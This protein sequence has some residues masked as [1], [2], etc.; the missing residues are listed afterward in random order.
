MKLFCF[1]LLLLP[2]VVTIGQ[3]L[4]FKK[5]NTSSSAS[6]RGLS[7]VDNRTAWVSGTKGSVGRTTDGGKTWNIQRIPGFE[8]LDFRSLYA[9]NSERAIIAN[10][11]SPA[12][13]LI[14]TNGGKSWKTVYT[15]DQKDAFF[16]GIDFWDDQNGLIYGDP[17]EGKMLL[18]RTTDGGL[19][20]NP[21]KEPPMLETGEASF[22]ASGTGIRCTNKKAVMICTGGTVSRLWIS[23]NQG[24]HWTNLP[25]PILQG[26]SSTGIFSF[27]LHN[28][29]L[30]IVGGDYKN[31]A[32]N[33]NHNF[34]SGDGGKQWTSPVTPVRGYRECIEVIAEKTLVS[35]GPTGT[36]IS[37][38]DGRNWK[39]LSDDTGLH[40]LR[41]ARNGSLVIVAGSEG[42]IFLVEG[43]K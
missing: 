22:A 29:V 10:A 37:Y 20:W 9:F 7:V 18:L 2:V 19:T 6:F 35:T 36:D 4:Q 24:E 13:I 14:T 12:Y 34:Y 25:T 17:I 43:L 31:M 1:A 38:D 11:G 16:D 26:E 39:A 5:I 21:V 30:H 42:R 8:E 15:N 33:K 27:V 23:D 28:G 41:K 32:L 40:V 3:P